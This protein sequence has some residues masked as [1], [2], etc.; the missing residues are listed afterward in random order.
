MRWLKH[1]FAVDPPGRAEPTPE[2]REAVQRI[3]REIVRRHLMLPA[4]VCLQ[5]ARPL[6]YV[7]AQAMHFCEPILAA[8]FNTA[9]YRAFAFF[10]EHRGSIDYLCEE[11]ER[12]EMKAT[13]ETRRHGEEEASRREDGG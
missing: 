1:A 13:T 7:G 3:C 11:L 2:Q 10:L 9:K 6:N 4:L 8:F 5:M 12:L